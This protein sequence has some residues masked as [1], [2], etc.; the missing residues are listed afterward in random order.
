MRV[1]RRDSLPMDRGCPARI[2]FGRGKEKRAR[3]PAVHLQR[4]KLRAQNSFPCY[5]PL[6]NRGNPERDT[7]ALRKH[8]A[9]TTAQIA[10]KNLPFSS[11]FAGP[12]NPCNAGEG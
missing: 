5:F 8:N 1:E 12:R 9:P 2:Y 10:R 6:F 4:S 3:T 11:V 7:V